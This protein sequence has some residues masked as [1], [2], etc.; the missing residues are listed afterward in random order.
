MIN[1][2]VKISNSTKQSDKR[3]VTVC[4]LVQYCCKG[5]SKRCRKWPF[6]GCCRRETPQPI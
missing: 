6:S 4:M 3:Q 1:L 2:A 5:R